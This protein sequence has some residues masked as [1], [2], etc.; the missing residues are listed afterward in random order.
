MLGLLALTVALA[1][2]VA[3]ALAVAA[4]AVVVVVETGFHAHVCAMME[5][6]GPAQIIY[7]EPPLFH[8]SHILREIPVHPQNND[9]LT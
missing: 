6:V 4:A 8:F 9:P 7:P 1:V 5:L 2:A 3:V